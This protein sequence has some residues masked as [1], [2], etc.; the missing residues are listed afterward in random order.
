MLDPES[1]KKKQP[2][3]SFEIFTRILVYNYGRPFSWT[4][5]SKFKVCNVFLNHLSSAT[6]CILRSAVHGQVAAQKQ[7]LLQVFHTVMSV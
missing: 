4:A 6:I 3:R 1:K 5:L 2:F 7:D